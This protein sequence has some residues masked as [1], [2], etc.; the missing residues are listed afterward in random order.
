ML[1]WGKLCLPHNRTR[2]IEA[3]TKYYLP[4]SPDGLA[5][6]ALELAQL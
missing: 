4:E 1:T 2:K 3:M 6:M 5:L